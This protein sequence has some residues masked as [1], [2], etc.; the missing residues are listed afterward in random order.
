MIKKEKIY[1][2]I[3]NPLFLFSFSLFI[4][5][6]YYYILDSNSLE[7][8]TDAITFNLESGYYKDTIEIRL[9]KD[10]NLPLGSS[11]YYTLNGDDPTV[12]DD[13][14][15][16]KIILKKEDKLKIYPLKV[17]AYFGNH[18]SNVYEH[19]YLLGDDIGENP[20]PII[21]IT[22]DSKNLYD[23]ETGIMVPG[24][25]WDDNYKKNSKGYISGN[26]NN[27]SDEWVKNSYVTYFD[28]SGNV[29]FKHN[30]GL[31]IS[32][33][34]SSALDTRSLKIVFGD[35]NDK[36][37][38][39]MNFY[40][41][42]YIAKYS[43]I[44]EFGDLRLKL[45]SDAE[46]GNIRSS[47]M[48][49][50]AME[51]NFDGA[52]PTQRAVAYLNGELYGIVDIQPTYSNSFLAKK[53]SLVDSNLIDKDKGGEKNLFKAYGI[54]KYFEADLNI[55]ENR[56]TLEKYVD[57]DNML[58]YY[59]LEI[60]MDNPDWPINNMEVW[61]YN[62]EYD[63]F[64][65][66][67]DGRIRFLLYD[68]DWIY[69][70]AGYYSWSHNNVFDSIMNDDPDDIHVSVFKKLMSYTYYRDKFLTLTLDLLNTSFKE[71][72][73]L[74]IIDEE[75][76]KIRMAFKRN[77]KVSMYKNFLSKIDELSEEASNQDDV[78]LYYFKKYF[79]VE[80]KYKAEIK[81]STGIEIYWNNMSLYQNQTY[82][83]YYY[84]NTELR[85]SYKE[86]PGY[87]FKYWLVNGEK[88]FD[89]D[90]VIMGGI[91]D[92]QIEAV[93]EY[94]AKSNHLIVNEIYANGSYDWIK[95]KNVGFE[96]IDISK[97]YLSDNINKLNKY[98]LPDV[99]LKTG[100][101]IIIYGKKYNFVINSYKSNLSLSDN[102]KLIL[103]K[104]G[105]ILDEIVIPYMSSI[106]TY[107]RYNNSN[108][109]VF[110]NQSSDI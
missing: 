37:K 87:K 84:S 78:L 47:I 72:N 38:F 61:K 92:I 68:S 2:F 100:Q 85:L 109:F 77:Y 14:Y 98:K 90:L 9:K 101:E 6:V 26:Y 25:T 39:V 42:D 40:E 70:P 107:G 5:V 7:S 97:Y 110:F 103:S 35:D 96:N 86:Y 23:Y 34:T 99:I 53:Y 41:D 49:R 31:G 15:V 65:K 17:V 74:N 12:N 60:L 73:L 10:I 89:D 75:K 79:G 45:G 19:D 64:N 59:V 83:N 108:S 46:N 76:W 29:I 33:G 88:I 105:K 106:E 8:I 55:E 48:S 18:Y 24:K 54:D 44:D 71:E 1:K 95:I 21:S 51:S 62:G 67:T 104:D 69:R 63:G 13:Q 80:K 16:D 3:K 36:T 28:S 30:C 52:V 81:S 32:G 20:I 50:L 57:M 82:L 22:S 102:K 66:Y 4:V 93:A 43:L 91:N 27:R 56:K 94:E 11:I 58:L